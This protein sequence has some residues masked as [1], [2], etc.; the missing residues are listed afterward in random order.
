MPENATA[1]EVAEELLN[2]ARLHVQCRDAAAASVAV[3]V[4]LAL[5]HGDRPFGKPFGLESGAVLVPTV[6]GGPMDGPC[7]VKGCSGHPSGLDS[8]A[9][10]EARGVTP[11]RAGAMFGAALHDEAVWLR[12]RVA[13]LSVALTAA[14]TE[15]DEHG[16]EYQHRTPASSLAAW[17]ALAGGAP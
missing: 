1:T 15:L 16:R 10:L 13:S 4:Y 2:L 5:K 11:T 14:C 3:N 6:P 12:E 9:A 7:P 8:A 17:R